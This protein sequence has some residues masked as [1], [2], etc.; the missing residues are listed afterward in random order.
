MLSNCLTAAILL[1]QVCTMISYQKCRAAA[2]PATGRDASR[3]IVM[4]GVSVFPVE[5]MRCAE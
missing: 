1:S 4:S 2:R 3:D 5:Q